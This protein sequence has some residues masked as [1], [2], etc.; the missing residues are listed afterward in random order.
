MLRRYNRLLVAIHVV[1]DALSAAAAFAA[2]LLHP[3]RD[4]F[5]ESCRSPRASRRSRSYLMLAAVHRGA[6]SPLAFQLQGLYRLRRGR[7]RVDDFF[8]GARRQHPRRARSASSAR[9]TSQTYHLSDALEPR[10][11]S[12]V[13]RAGLGALPRPER[14]SSP[15]PRARSCAT[16]CGAAGARAS[17]CKRVLIVGVGDLGRHGRRPHPRAQRAGLQAGRL[18]RR[19]RRRRPTPSAIAAC[20]CSAPSIRSP[21]ICAQ[22]ADRRDLRRAAASTST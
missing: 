10:A 2:R 18:R 17:A 20:R 22:R 9:C 13:S 11:T 4:G 15:T 6:A 8:G 5:A 12:Q 7:T 21:E 16:C 1:A 19:S 3:V 14:R